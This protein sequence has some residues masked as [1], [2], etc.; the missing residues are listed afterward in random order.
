MKLFLLFISFFV[1]IFFGNTQEINCSKS[2][3]SQ[4]KQKSVNIQRSD[5]ERMN[6]YNITYLVMDLNISSKN[7]KISGYVCQ[8]GYF[9]NESDSILLELHPDYQIDSILVNNT[10][11]SF[12][13]RNYLLIIPNKHKQFN[14]CVFYHGKINNIQSQFMG[15]QGIINGTDSYSQNKVTYTLSEPFSASDWWPS[16]QSL[17]DKIDSADLYFTTEAPDLVGSNGILISKTNLENNLRKFHWKTRY[18]T[19]YYLF[20]FAVGPYLDYSFKTFLPNE[21]DSIL[22]QNFIYADSIFFRLNKN[23]IDLTGEYLKTFSSI[24]G[25]YPFKNEKYGHCLSTINGGMEHQT[26]TTL[27][28]FNPNL[29][30]HEL[31]HQWF[32]D[33]VTCSS[34][35]DI[36]L[37]EG[38]A[39]YSE[40][41]IYER[42][43]P[44]KKDI[45][46]NSFI[47]RAKTKKEG[48]V[49]VDDTLNESRIFSRELSYDKGALI[50]HTLRYL[51]NN[52]SL[53]FKSLK[54][55]QLNFSHSFACVS[56]FKKTVEKVCN[57]DLSNFFNE[58]YYGQGY[59]IYA[60]RTEKDLDTKIYIQ[61]TTTSSKTPLFTTPIEVLVARQDL[62]DSILKLS[63]SKNNEVFTYPNSLKIDYIKSIDPNNYILHETTPY[64]SLQNT[65]NETIKF[66]PNPCQ[67]ELYIE[68]SNPGNYTFKL[69]DLQGREVF[70]KEINSSY[71]M[72][73]EKFNK[74]IYLIVISSENTVISKKI[75][76]E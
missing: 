7:T 19:T 61:Q 64:S 55:Y 32:G 48:S 36:W 66:Y 60:Y 11:S 67:N 12:F 44:D 63:I 22:I 3:K 9:K 41:L 51:V 15:G 76:F 52:D 5:L 69:I 20:S 14:V 47:Y 34:Y 28:G 33:H 38:F 2:I 16:K 59:P 57:L 74:G 23:N 29:V 31:A 39:T 75:M 72:N 46:L 53:F 40:Y 1:V 4:K 49:F 45:I 50:I 73:T 70:I 25:T 24:Y 68:I 58:W 21:K 10:K 35:E 6:N 17:N 26:M 42:L 43:F 18:P 13:Q 30:A 65:S 27:N 62:P 8:N 54:E 37:N 71:K 56:D